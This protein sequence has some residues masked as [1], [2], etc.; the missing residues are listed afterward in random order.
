MSV[1]LEGWP[2]SDPPGGQ[3]RLLP[4]LGLRSC[5]GVWTCVCDCIWVCFVLYLHL[6]ACCL[7]GFC[8]WGAGI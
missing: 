7:R 3:W 8:I 6:I 2:A 1:R 5:L 4:L